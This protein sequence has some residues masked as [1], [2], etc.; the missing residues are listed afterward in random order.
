V[1]ACRSAE[2]FRPIDWKAAYGALGRVRERFLHEKKNLAPAQQAALQK[3]FEEDVFIKGM[4]ALRQ[5][6]EHVTHVR[7]D[8]PGPRISTIQ[9]APIQLTVESSAAA[10]F[11]VAVPVLRDVMNKPHAIDHL[12]MLE[13]AQRRICAA[14]VRAR[15]SA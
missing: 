15:S 1:E 6:S 11:S 14:L 13:E 8:A 4:M 3:V 9:N 2:S 7:R 5:V 12:K 10:A